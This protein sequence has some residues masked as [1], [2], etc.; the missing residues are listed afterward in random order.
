MGAPFGW[1]MRSLD[2]G[3][4]N[5]G[6]LFLGILILLVIGLVPSGIQLAGSTLYAPDSIA[7]K[8]VYVAAM[9][10][11]LVIM[12]PLMGSAFRLIDACERGAPARATGIL[13][14]YR[15]GAFW[16]RTVLL[17]LSFVAVYVL[18]GGALYLLLPGG[19]ATVEYFAQ[20]A[21]T[22]PGGQPDLSGLTAPP[23]GLFLWLLGAMFLLL[24]LGNAYMLAFAQAALAGRGVLEALGD[25]FAGAFRN[26]LPFLGFAIAMFFVAIVG[27]LIAGILIVLIVA[28]IAMISKT[29]A[30]VVAIPLYIA[31]MLA[32]YVVMFGFYYHAWREIHAPP[33]TLPVGDDGSTLAA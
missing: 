4:R 6:A 30:L 3:R 7:F 20:L 11:S 18:V 28:V 8:T 15:D 23:G 33:G 10:V 14:G 5:P 16:L 17:S 13:D 27:L 24:V 32:M 29:L 12:P 31:L 9:L 22:P 19:A 21:A 25:G 26:L 1:L 2:V